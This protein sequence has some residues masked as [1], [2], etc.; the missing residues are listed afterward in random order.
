MWGGRYSEGIKENKAETIWICNNK[1]ESYSETMFS[2]E[3]RRS[4]SVVDI[5]QKVKKAKLKQYGH[6]TRRI[7]KLL[8][9]NV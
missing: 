1:K 4:S 9:D 8:R 3:I 5:T 6:V 7:G 2:E